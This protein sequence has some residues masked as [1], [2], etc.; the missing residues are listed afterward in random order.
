[1]NLF[2]LNSI[3]QS[4]P[5]NQ[6]VMIQ[7]VESLIL[8]SAGG[9]INYDFALAGQMAETPLLIEY[10]IFKSLLKTFSHPL[11][12]CRLIRLASGKHLLTENSFHRFRRQL[13]YL[14]LQAESSVLEIETESVVLSALTPYSFSGKLSHSIHN[15]SLN[16]AFYLQIELSL[17]IT[18]NA[19]YLEPYYLDILTP[20]LFS[21]LLIT[22]KD[23]LNNSPLAL[24]KIQQL[25][26][27]IEKLIQD[28]ETVFVNF[29]NS[30]NSE[31]YYQDIILQI[32]RTFNDYVNYL[33][34]IG[35]Q[36]VTIIESMFK[37]VNRGKTRRHFSRY[38]FAKRLPLPTVND[39]PLFNKPIFIVSTPRAG[40]TLLFETLAQFPQLWTTGEENH[41]LIE[42]I[43]SLHP[44][45]HDFKSNRLTADDVN[46]SIVN[47]LKQRFVRQLQNRD[48]ENYLKLDKNK[49][50]L[51][52]RFLEKTPKNALRIPF[53][54]AIFPD[55]LFIY[56]Y[57]DPEENISSL[58]EG[59]RSLQFIAYRQ[60][61]QW[62]HQQWSFFLPEN[63]QT[64]HSAA[65]VEIAA[66]QW[67]Y[68]ND[69]IVND[70]YHLST[71]DWCAIS[72]QELINHPQLTLNRLADFAG[73]A[74]DKTIDQLFVE[75]LPISR[76][77]LS[78]PAQN[79]WR[80]HSVEL[81]QVLTKLKIPN[82]VF[83]N[84]QRR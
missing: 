74:L 79:K 1:M 73:L 13:V 67:Q 45:A 31:L 25:T 76:L 17:T 48:G 41:E 39:C 71:N 70:L 9:S 51:S 53:F 69:I 37:T 58:L 54:K 61:P 15:T 80:R 62:Q 77:T 35:K 50:P 55:A 75:K 11:S 43:A 65:L 14:A 72:Y 82:S 59:W 21:S 29:G 19:Q 5:D 28:W 2:S 22:L 49:R 26:I 24:D 30:W 27:V 10:P 81:Q 20:K 52:I 56:L 8:I 42:D 34:E 68:C 44:S 12:R 7:N 60:L 3:I 78:N 38:L 47:E 4:I 16:Y 33:S 32:S 57:R 83:D 63:W 46:E 64:L 40:S 66:Y 23:D 36:T 84:V 6:W 18:D